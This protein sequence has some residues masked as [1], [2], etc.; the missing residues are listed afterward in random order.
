MRS[1]FLLYGSYGYTGSLIVREAL[2]RGFRPL[3]AG[4]NSEKLGRQA[5]AFGLE[6]L[7]FDLEDTPKL[8]EALGRTSLV[9]NVAGPFSRT[10]GPVAMA[11]LRVGTHY[12]DITGEIEVFEALATLDTRAKEAGVMIL[13]GVGFDVVPSD[14]LAAHLH[15]R[16]P[17]ATSLTLALMVRGGGVSRGTAVTAVENL[18]NGGLV[19][20]AG[21]LIPV[22]LAWRTREVDFGEGPISVTTIPWGDVSTAHLST[23]IPDIDV[24]ARVPSAARRMMIAG[25]HL[26]WALGTGILESVLKAV[27]RF[28][29]AGPTAEERAGGESRIWGEVT[30][31]SGGSAV[32]RLRTPEGYTFTAT[33]SVAIVERILGGAA[34]AGFRTPSLAYGPDWILELA[35]V[36]REDVEAAPS[37]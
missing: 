29:S 5:A 4:R 21:R 15:R 16:L 11:C 6:R 36:V 32:S 1:D 17:S 37:G 12:L 33:T 26:G 31:P 25:G 34:P 27:I 9:L 22:P 30:D 23:G 35:G 28:R 7:V 19:R 18:R 24:Y 8:E 14:C 13:P 2:G 20:R 3:L 10:A